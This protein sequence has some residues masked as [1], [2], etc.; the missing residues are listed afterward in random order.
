MLFVNGGLDKR[1]NKLSLE[2]SGCIQREKV[3]KTNDLIFFLLG[4]VYAS[5]FTN[6]N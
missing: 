5:Q 1:F 3:L 4:Q 6:I 2:N